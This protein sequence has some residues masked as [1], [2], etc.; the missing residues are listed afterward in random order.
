M[1]GNKMLLMIVSVLIILMGL[2]EAATDLLGD[3]RMYHGIL[4]II[5]GIVILAIAY[6]SKE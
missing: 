2:L 5:I 1:I 3:Y 4:I 6:K